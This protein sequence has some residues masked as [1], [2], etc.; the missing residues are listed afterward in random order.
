MKNTSTNILTRLF[1][2][3]FVP[4][5]MTVALLVGLTGYF[6]GRRT[7]AQNTVEPSGAQTASDAPDFVAN[8]GEV[9][10]SFVADLTLD[11]DSS[12]AGVTALLRQSD[13]KL[14]VA[15]TFANVGGAS[16]R[17]LVRLNADSSVDRSFDVNFSINSISTLVQQADGKILVGGFF[18][19][20]NT[21]NRNGILR[22]NADGSLDKTFETNLSSGGVQSITPLA[23]GKILITG[24]FGAIADIAFPGIALLNADGNLDET[25][26]PAVITNNGSQSSISVS[27]IQADGK[28]LIAGNFTNINGLTR[29]RLAR[30]NADGT[31]DLSFDTGLGP[32][33]QVNAIL[34]LANGKVLIGGDFTSFNGIVRGKIARLNADGT[35]DATFNFSAQTELTVRT[36]VLQPDGK[37]LVAA[38]PSFSSS[39]GFRSVFRLNADGGVDSTFDILSANSTAA[40]NGNVNTLI[41]E[42]DGKVI[43]GGTFTTVNGQPRRG[44][45]R[46]NPNGMLDASFAVVFGANGT[47]NVVAVQPDGKI[48]ISGNFTYVNGVP[49]NRIA[50][51]NTDGSL[52]ATF[53]AVI[54][55]TGNLSS[56]F[57]I[58][59]IAVQPDGKI[60]I[61]GS[62]GSG[63][64]N[65]IF[66]SGLTRL[67]ADGST[68]ASFRTVHVG[69]VYTIAV[70]PDG[71]ILI[72]GNF[73]R[74]ENTTTIRNLARFNADGSF[75]TAFDIGTGPNNPVT[76]IA[77]QTDGKI[78]IAG[79]FDSFNGTLRRDIARINSNGSLDT[80]FTADINSSSSALVVQP[81]GKILVGGGFSQV[82]GVNRNR[83]ARL[84]ADGSLD[85]SFGGF[86][87][88]EGNVNAVELQSD[89]KIYVAGNFNQISGAIRRKIVRLNADGSVDAV[90]NP[91]GGADFEVLA[92]AR[93]SD[94]KIIVGGSF[95]VFD[96]VPR[97]GIARLR[98]NACVVSPLFDFDGDGRTDIGYYRPSGGEWNRL[99]T[100]GGKTSQQLF[101]LPTDRIV[102]ADYDG[103]GRTDIAV[104]RP[105][106]G[107]WYILNSR[108]GFQAIQFGVA[109]DKPIA[110]DYDGDGRDDLAVFRPS[111]GNWYIRRSSLGFAAVNFGIST[112]VPVIADMDGDCKA[113]IAVF[114]PSNGVWYWLQSSDGGFRAAQFGANGDVPVAGDYDG[115]AKTDLAVFRPSVGTWYLLKSREGFSSIQFG[116]AADKPVPAD[117]DG[118]GK[119]DIAVYRNGNWYVLNSLSGRLDT[120]QFG[121]GDDQPIPTAYLMR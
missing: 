55:Q 93:Q 103:D 90:F 75:D 117:Y 23:N 79:S 108:A 118:D 89:G 12:G 42:S 91:E 46:L 2:G 113:D 35:L 43:I 29:N 9:D 109:E 81:D 33:G 10:T 111:T 80:T 15:G 17:N 85:L 19:L 99:N 28:I 66:F 114:R 56:S 21:V 120:V 13:G 41:L 32:N 53:N 24:S 84:N 69:S 49:R 71:K 62:Y 16:K 36:M 104:Y 40:P 83:L 18:S 63:A 45:A 51:L 48:L 88:Q 73:S 50:R 116:I 101:G 86:I 72:G 70:Q 105:A 31:L 102:P 77:V 112:D 22:L 59:A 61:G 95:T 100:S 98:T 87:G 64:I 44:L 38:N 52:D 25:F 20:F 1:V 5:A 57:L 8:S 54:T 65:N 92:L 7:A 14:L 4:A 96:G 39:T 60:L 107:I 106:Q 110:A 6:A 34:P 47:V 74:T 115:D 119:T 68:D 76:K 58:S 121:L 11:S 3:R 94:G 37:I 78:I 26:N 30:L 82:N 67:N 97:T 27:A